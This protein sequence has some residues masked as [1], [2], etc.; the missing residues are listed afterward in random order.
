MPGHAI[1]TS[2][3]DTNEAAQTLAE[4][5]VEARLGACAQI[6]G[7]ITSVYRWEG[8]IRS[9]PEWRIEIKTPTDRVAAL[10]RHLEAAHPY[11]I[12]EIVVTPITDGAAPYLTW[13]T[14][15]TRA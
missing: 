2:T 8:T 14:T 11:E 1:V 12:P 5:I 13:L 3:T 15:E 10:I 7:P 4:G 6:T 9:E